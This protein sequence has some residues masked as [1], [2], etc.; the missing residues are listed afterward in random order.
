MQCAACTRRF[1]CW[2]FMDM[3]PSNV[4]TRRRGAASRE[5]AWLNRGMQIQGPVQARQEQRV[6]GGRDGDF[7]LGEKVKGS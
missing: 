1:L 2:D 5:L 4:K 6:T 3:V 7:R